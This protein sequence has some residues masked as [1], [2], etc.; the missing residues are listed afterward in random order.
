MSLTQQT[1]DAKSPVRKATDVFLQA[2]AVH[3]PVRWFAQHSTPISA[4]SLLVFL[5][6]AICYG[7]VNPGA[8]ETESFM[9]AFPV[10]IVSIL[11]TV[12]VAM[13]NLY[14]MSTKN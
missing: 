13:R 1:T 14:E 12:V 9:F 3:G 2:K 10:L 6:T 8:T 7:I 11:A 5:T 4:L